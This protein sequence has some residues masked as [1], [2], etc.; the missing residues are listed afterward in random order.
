MDDTGGIDL[1]AMAEMRLHASSPHTLVEAQL[2]P[3]NN[4]ILNTLVEMDKESAE[5]GN[6]DHQVLIFVRIALGLL[7]GLSTYTVKLNVGTAHVHIRL[8][9]GKQFL[10]SVPRLQGRWMKFHIKMI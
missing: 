5:S 6:P 2:R 3:F 4:L 9:E 7:Q 1:R 8:Y 10:A